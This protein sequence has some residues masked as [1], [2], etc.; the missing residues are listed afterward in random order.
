MREHGIEPCHQHYACV[1]D[2][3]ARAGYL[4][5]AFIINMRIEPGLSVKRALLSACK[6]PMQQ[7]ENMLQTVCSYL[8]HILQGVM[9][10]CQIF[11]LRV[12]CGIVLQRYQYS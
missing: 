6:I 9:F 11:M 5:Q 10:S 12:A 8:T 1:V 3:L 7:R 4:N 2:L